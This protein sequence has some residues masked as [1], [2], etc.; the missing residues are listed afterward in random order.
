M[1]AIIAIPESQKAAQA[2]ELGR[3]EAAIAVL[4]GGY[5]RGQ[6][7]RQAPS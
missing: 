4:S 3:I 5:G 2:A 7:C 1:D 6:A